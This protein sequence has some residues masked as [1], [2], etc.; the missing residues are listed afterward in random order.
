[1]SQFKIA[2]VIYSAANP[3]LNDALA[4]VYGSPNRPLC[5]CRR[6]GIEMVIAKLGEKYIIKRMPHS[7]SS[8]AP[9]CDSYEPPAELSGLGEI[10]GKAIRINPVDGT[11]TLKFDFALSKH[12]ARAT[13][14][15]SGIQHNS[16]HSDGK[17]LTLRG[18]LHYLYDE[19]RF[20]HWS[21]KMAEKR[22]WWVIR[23]YLLQAAIDKIVKNIP[24]SHILYV[25]ESF[26]VEKKDEITH[27][28]LAIFNGLAHSNSARQRLMILI[29]ELKEL[30]DARFGKKI[31]IKHLADAPFMVSENMYQR[32]LKRF[33]HELMLR[34]SI[35]SSHL[36][37]IATFHV[38][39]AGVP[40]IEEISLMLVD[41]NWIPFENMN[42]RILINALTAQQ[43]RFIKGMRY[44]L[45][46]THPLASAVITDRSE[47]IALYITPLDASDLYRRKLKELTEA[48][49]LQSWE[50]DTRHSMPTLPS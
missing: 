43:R 12:S 47:P 34:S 14:V 5:L 45:P 20:T 42:E 31:V 26:L 49:H 33:E 38:S 15:Q 32:L 44:N 11:T 17:N 35:A 46:S 37:A 9:S 1:M 3:R 50:W 25:P 27:R 8:H 41:E 36:I 39:R 18:V 29:G 13:S 22:N 7:G 28:R 19:A 4:A 2:N 30:S 21:P 24:L 48:S 16:V 10:I 6:N 40:S 23:K